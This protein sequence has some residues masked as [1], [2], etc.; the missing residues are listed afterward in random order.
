[1]KRLHDDALRVIVET[2]LPL[3]PDGLVVVD[4]GKKE[5]LGTTE[6]KKLFEALGGQL[7]NPEHKLDLTWRIFKRGRK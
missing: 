4:Q 1:M 3:P 5:G 7:S 2:P 6:A